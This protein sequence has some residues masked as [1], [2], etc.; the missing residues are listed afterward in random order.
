MV[1]QLRMA[2][3]NEEVLQARYQAKRDTFREIELKQRLA[4]PDYC[5][6]LTSS[7]AHS[8][9]ILFQTQKGCTTTMSKHTGNV[10]QTFFYISE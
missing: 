4:F 6:E 1:V 2:D 8:D 7:E 10:L 5:G 3:D 9:F